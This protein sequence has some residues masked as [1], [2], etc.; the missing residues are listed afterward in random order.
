MKKAE[1][2]DPFDVG[3]IRDLGVI[4]L[5]TM[6][7]KLNFHFSVT[8]DLFGSE[9]STNAAN[10]YSASLKGRFKEHKIEDDHLLTNDTYPVKR[11]LNGEYK[12]VE[13]SALLSLNSRL[14]DDYVAECENGVRRWNKIIDTYGIDFSLYVPHRAFHRKVGLFADLT[15]D[16]H[17]TLVDEAE[18][19]KQKFQW[20]PSSNDAEYLT[21]LMQAQRKVGQFASWIAPPKSGIDN[22]PGD[23]EYVRLAHKY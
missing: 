2:D 19:E 18:W 10:S 9:I 11:L 12:N 17:G 14:C 7:R 20:L 21:S 23:F 16:P 6:Q 5:P 4:D 8:I 15:A 22:K 3:R 13:E 1:I